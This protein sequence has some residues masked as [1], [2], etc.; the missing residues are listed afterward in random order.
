MELNLIISVLCY[1]CL[2]HITKCYPF[3]M[4]ITNQPY[5]SC[6][7]LQL[8]ATEKQISELNKCKCEASCELNGVVYEDGQSWMDGCIE[9]TC[10]VSKDEGL[11]GRGI[12]K[13]GGKETDFRTDQM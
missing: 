9:C 3:E 6:F 13:M 11:Q 5:F 4:L 7:I 2:F 10:R 8:L 1:H 12:Y